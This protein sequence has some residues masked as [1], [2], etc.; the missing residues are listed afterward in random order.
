MS[1]WINESVFY[2]IY[3]LGFCGAPSR[4]DWGE[5]VP[6]IKKVIEWI[7]H[8]KKI[9]V[10][11]I[12]FGPLFESTEHG[13]DTA[14]YNKLDRR[15]GTNEDFKKVCEELH[16]DG[17]KVVVDGVFNHVGRDFWAFKD[18]QANKQSSRYCGWFENLNFGGQSPMGDPFWYEGWEGHYNLVKLNLKNQEVV[19]YLLDA[20]GNWMKEY[21]I[22]GLRLDV[23]YC[24]D[25]DFFRK[26]N[27]YCK[28]KREDF[29]LMG[30]MVHGDYA[31]LA[32]P[33]ML[34]LIHI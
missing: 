17:I 2:H 15:L 20:V 22:D 23:A 6:R 10:N 21:K 8:L 27:A 1:N 12:Y 32:K 5:T 18:V 24:M 28:G 9:G 29:W 16:K 13:Y 11:A 14:D 30:E 3:P 4:N 31:R 19:D 26:L 7:P 25:E 34:S 33:G